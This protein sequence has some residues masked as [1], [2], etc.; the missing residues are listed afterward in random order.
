[1]KR[2]NIG[3]ITMATIKE[4]GK[5]KIDMEIRGCIDC[6][7]EYSSGW[8]VARIIEVKI[9]GKVYQGQL[10]RCADCMKNKQRLLI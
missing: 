6:G 10:H 2:V 5:A 7:T 3:G 4:I 8:E 1:M 9:G